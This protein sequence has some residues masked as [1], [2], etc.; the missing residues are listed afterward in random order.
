VTQRSQ[1]RP[2]TVSAATQA[3]GRAGTPADGAFRLGQRTPMAL[4]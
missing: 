3:L 1:R 2:R 4:S